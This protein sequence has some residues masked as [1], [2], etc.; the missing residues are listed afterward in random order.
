MISIAE[1]KRVYGYARV[2]SR[3]QNLDRQITQ[4]MKAGVSSR[5]IICDKQSGK[6][7]NRQGYKQLKE[8]LLRRGDV[9]VV[10]EMDRLGRNLNDIRKE[11][12]DLCEMGVNIQFLD[13][14]MISTTEKSDIEKQLISSVLFEIMGYLAEKERL[15]I[16]QRC[17]EGIVNAKRN[18]VKFGR[19][20]IPKPPEWNDVYEQWKSGKIT[21]VRAMEIL[22]LKRSTFYRFAKEEH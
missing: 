7:F 22:N 10:T 18:G 2:S 16:R 19:P 4:L 13:N 17:E 11:Y 15:K 3:E 12:S 9:L 21:A 6:D 20:K 5:D 1:E 14:P 8:Q